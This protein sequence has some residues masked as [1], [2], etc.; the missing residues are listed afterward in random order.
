MGMYD[1]ADWEGHIDTQALIGRSSDT[2]LAVENHSLR[3]RINRL[4]EQVERQRHYIEL[5]Q[6]R[7]LVAD[8]E[9]PKE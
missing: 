6:Q 4:E 8:E 5:L 1:E 7:L 3:E 2:M 9:V